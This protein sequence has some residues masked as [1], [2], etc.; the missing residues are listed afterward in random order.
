MDFEIIGAA[1]QSVQ[2][3]LK[4][5][6]KLHAGLGSL[7]WLQGDMRI[8]STL[9]DGISSVVGRALPV[10]VQYLNT[11]QCQGGEAS[12]TFTTQATGEIL[13][14][15]LKPDEKL[16]CRHGVL[17]VAAG[18]VSVHVDIQENM[19]MGLLNQT[20]L[21]VEELIGPGKLY[22]A[23]R[24]D[25]HEVELKEGQ[26][27]KANPDRVACY[28]PGV[29]REV[30]LIRSV[31][32]LQP[33]GDHLYLVNFSGPGKVWLQGPALSELVRDHQADDTQRPLSTE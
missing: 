10:D 17:L 32:P 4:E 27:I 15:E 11:Y 29:Q 3:K 8:T 1:K 16:I 14:M 12:I 23:L 24:G 33:G 25:M 22:L 26:S 2:V 30:E 21:F 9:K 13:E 19:Q 6:E 18:S 31:R 28:Q 5:G 20:N 7:S